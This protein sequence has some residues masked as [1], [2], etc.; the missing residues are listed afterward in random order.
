MGALL[1]RRERNM[2]YSPCRHNGRIT[3][4]KAALQSPVGSWRAAMAVGIIGAFPGK[5]GRPPAPQW[6]QRAATRLAIIRRYRGERAALQLPHDGG[7]RERPGGMSCRQLRDLPQRIVGVMIRP[8]RNAYWSRFA[9]SGDRGRNAKSP[10]DTAG[11]TS[12]AKQICTMLS[13]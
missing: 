4:Q 6:S 8:R 7:A 5:K 9:A 10:G 3:G 2:A 11:C 12:G 13:T 1:G